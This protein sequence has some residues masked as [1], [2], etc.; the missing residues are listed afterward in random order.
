MLII[1]IT[2][3]TCHP[4]MMLFNNLTVCSFFFSAAEHVAINNLFRGRHTERAQH[5]KSTRSS[6]RAAATGTEPEQLPTKTIQGWSPVGPATVSG[7]APGVSYL[8]AE[9]ARLPHGTRMHRET[10]FL[11]HTYAKS[12]VHSRC[13]PFHPRHR[14]QASRLQNNK[15]R[16]SVSITLR[17]I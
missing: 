6:V 11:S 17:R 9:L 10:Q 12:H 7:V 4:W 15:T 5:M 13:N 16:Q 8:L 1:L 3:R 2:A 14:R